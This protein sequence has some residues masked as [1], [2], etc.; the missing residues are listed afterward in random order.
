MASRVPA[1]AIKAAV[2]GIGGLGALGVTLNNSLFNVEGG[3]RAVVFNRFVGIKEQVYGEGM[4]LMVPFVD[5]PE[6][7]NVR[8]RPRNFGSKTGSK[9]LQMVGIELRVLSRP[10]VKHLPAI[11]R[12]LGKDFDDRVLPSI[13]QE[14][15]KSVVAQ[16]N[17]SQL[18]SQRERVSLLVRERLTER[19]AQ[20]HILLEDVSIVGLNFGAEYSAAIEAKQVAQ[21]EAERAKFIVEKAIQEKIQTLVRAEGDAK[22]AKMINDVVGKD[23][24]YLEL[25]RIDAARS[26]AQVMSRASNRIYL[27]SDN[28]LFGQLAAEDR[29]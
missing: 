8:A 4:H 19:A 13:V 10:D 1:G 25:R 3:H 2:I 11:Y 9:D 23:P 20:F 29:Q 21:Q 22:S 5:R 16:F 14:V 27:S 7:Y 6:I 24:D 15:L 18:I 28:L 26:I 17:A 12:T